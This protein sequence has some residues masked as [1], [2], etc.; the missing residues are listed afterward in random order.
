MCR[1]RP[2]RLLFLWVVPVLVLSACRT[3]PATDD[4]IDFDRF[5]A[6]VPADAHCPDQDRLL[7]GAEK[8][9]EQNADARA[10]QAATQV[11]ADPCS[12]KNYTRA[13]K[14]A[15]DVFTQRQELARR[16][17][18]TWKGWFRRKMPQKPGFFQTLCGHLPSTCPPMR[19]LRRR[20]RPMPGK[21]LPGYG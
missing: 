15:G 7:A 16:F 8:F 2:L 1:C 12:R 10:L 19:S 13:L 4:R 20:M 21:R 9:L 5:P 3:G 14:I 18:F 6:A 11:I 17:I